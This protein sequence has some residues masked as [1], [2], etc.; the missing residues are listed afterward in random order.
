M[1]PANVGSMTIRLAGAVDFSLWRPIVVFPKSL[2]DSV[3]T[4]DDVLEAVSRA[5]RLAILERQGHRDKYGG[6]DN[7]R[8]RYASMPLNISSNR[9]EF[10]TAWWGGLY[11]SPDERDVWILHTRSHV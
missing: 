7:Q 5:F 4:V 1:R 8:R 10:Y 6:S 11:A 9:I 2:Y 3:V